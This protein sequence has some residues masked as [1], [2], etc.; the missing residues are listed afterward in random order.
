MKQAVFILAAFAISS[1]G[2]ASAKSYDFILDTPTKLGD[3]QLKAGQYSVKVNGN[4]AVIKDAQTG[5]SWSAPV[6]LET[7]DHKFDRTMVATQDQS[8]TPAV[9]EI[10]LGGST[11]KLAFSTPSGH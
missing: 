5:K 9:I 1:L 4:Q 6:T 3:T 8:G 10:D 11:T 7:S 2:V